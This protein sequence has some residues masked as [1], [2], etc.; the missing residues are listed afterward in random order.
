MPLYMVSMTGPKI[1]VNFNI[2]LGSII[3]AASV[4][5][6]Q[7]NVVWVGMAF[8]TLALDMITVKYAELKGISPKEV[9]IYKP[10]V[11]VYLKS[12]NVY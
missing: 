8:G 2:V 3:A 12:L 7:T 11:G 1:S 9:K 6:R 5:M 10:Q 4:L